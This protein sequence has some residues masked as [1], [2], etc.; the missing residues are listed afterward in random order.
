MIPDLD[1]E[2]IVI[3]R[4]QQVKEFI[5]MFS[6][7]REF[8]QHHHHF[9]AMA[10]TS[11]HVKRG[12]NVVTNENASSN[13]PATPHNYPLEK[14]DSA[15]SFLS[16]HQAVGS[17]Q[18][19]KPTL[20]QTFDHEQE[21]SDDIANVPCWATEIQPFVK[22]EFDKVFEIYKEWQ[23]GQIKEVTVKFETALKGISERAEKK[24]GEINDH[25][26]FMQSELHNLIMFQQSMKR[27]GMVDEK[28]NAND[29]F[30]RQ[31]NQQTRLV[32]DLNKLSVIQSIEL[33]ELSQY[34]ND[35]YHSLRLITQN[36]EQKHKAF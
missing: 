24:Y 14:R 36:A 25:F 18:N 33:Q 29:E 34:S 28:G 20:P 11:I 5:K 17:P 16:A 7:I 27:L 30:M 9:D 1:P 21:S 12:S 6:S 35:V 23:T 15:R 31:F 3:D 32:K 10:R 2:R 4:K 8:D 13:N 22:A 26:D 19:R